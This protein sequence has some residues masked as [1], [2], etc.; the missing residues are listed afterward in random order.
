MLVNIATEIIELSHASFAS[1]EINYEP[2][3]ISTDRRQPDP[4]KTTLVYWQLG[5]SGSK[6]GNANGPVHAVEFVD[7]PA[8]AYIKVWAMDNDDANAVVYPTDYL[9]KF[10]LLNVWLKKFEWTDATG[11]VVAAPVSYT[12]VGHRKRNLPVGG[13]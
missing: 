11:S 3:A 13:F 4:T 1:P 10:P 6:I 8:S 9:I 12:V 5:P 7:I 2:I